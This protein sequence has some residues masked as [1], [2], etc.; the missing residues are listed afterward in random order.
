MDIVQIA[1]TTLNFVLFFNDAENLQRGL[2]LLDETFEQYKLKINVSKTKTMILNFIKESGEY[3]NTVSN[4]GGEEVENV[5]VFRYLGCHIRF[6]EANTGDA[7]INLRIDSAESKFYELG[8]KFMNFNIK[9]ST[10]VLLLDLLVRSSLTYACQTWTLTAKLNESNQRIHRSYGKRR[11]VELHHVKRAY[12]WI[13]QI[14]DNRGI[15]QSSKATVRST[16]HPVPRRIFIKEATIQL[17]TK[18]ATRSKYNA[19][20]G[21]IPTGSMHWDDVPQECNRK[22]VL[23]YSRP[24][25][26]ETSCSCKWILVK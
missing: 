10:P 13:M 11:S 20:D 25:G 23:I 21:S 8:T 5:E 2:N 9:L 3:P 24:R 19:Q 17:R 7:E 4:L 22:E 14:Q 15:C 1:Q 12:S 16:Y 6:D 26:L 18:L